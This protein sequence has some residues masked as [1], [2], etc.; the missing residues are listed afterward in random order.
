MERFHF[1]VETCMELYSTGRKYVRRP[2]WQ[3]F[4]R[5]KAVKYGGPRILI[6]GLLRVTHES[7]IQVPPILNSKE[8]QK[9]LDTALIPLLNKDSVDMQDGASCHRSQSTL[10]FLDCR[11]VCLVTD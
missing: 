4:Y 6:W 3:R 10:H 2:I 11:Q 1:T 9:V 7:L 8:Y 5:M